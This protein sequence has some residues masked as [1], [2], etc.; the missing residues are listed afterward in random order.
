MWGSL[1]PALEMGQGPC[2]GTLG[3]PTWMCPEPLS[4]L[5]TGGLLPLRCFT[6]VDQTW[7]SPGACGDGLL[8]CT[9]VVGTPGAT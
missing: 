4:G 6:G 7:L 1:L 2:L 5:R 9:P 3:W 8:V